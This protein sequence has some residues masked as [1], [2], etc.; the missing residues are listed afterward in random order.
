MAN[1]PVRYPGYRLA[2]NSSKPNNMSALDS[3]AH[4]FENVVHVEDAVRGSFAR[5]AGVPTRA[6]FEK[7]IRALAL[8]LLAAVVLSVPLLAQAPPRIASAEP[9]SGKV[10]DMVTLTGEHLDKAT[11]TGVFLS[12]DKMDYKATIVDQS[13]QKIMIKVPKVKAGQYN[14][15]VQVANNIY[16]EPVH[17]TVQD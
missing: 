13:D 9:T 14:V 17:F 12:D 10:D 4:H 5:S 1:A 15:S 2:S 11:V 16:I 8:V 6:S 3:A 7:R